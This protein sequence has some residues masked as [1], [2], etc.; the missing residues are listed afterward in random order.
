MSGI[1]FMF[2][3]ALVFFEAC[4][5]IFYEAYSCIKN[6]DF[7]IV[8]KWVFVPVLLAGALFF[9]LVGAF[10]VYMTIICIPYVLN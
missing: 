8:A 7:S 10:I 9:F 6:K 2:L 5:Y 3:V 4:S 1:I